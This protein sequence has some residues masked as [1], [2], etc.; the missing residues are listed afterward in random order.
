M[1]CE[2]GGGGRTTDEATVREEAAEP[3]ERMGAWPMS[4]KESSLVS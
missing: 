3:A 1:F 2:N 4:G